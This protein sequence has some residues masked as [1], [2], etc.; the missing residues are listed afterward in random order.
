MLNH[1]AIVLSDTILVFILTLTPLTLLEMEKY[2]IVAARSVEAPGIYVR[3]IPTAASLFSISKLNLNR[4][5]V[6]AVNQG[7][8]LSVV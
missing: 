2:D 5:N 4:N 3:I 6:R 7:R 1:V 8:I